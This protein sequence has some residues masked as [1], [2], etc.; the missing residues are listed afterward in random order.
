MA[1]RFG[2]DYTRG[3]VGRRCQESH[4]SGANSALPFA[5][6]G[7]CQLGNPRAKQSANRLFPVP[8]SLIG[9]RVP[10]GLKH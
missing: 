6:W 4:Q 7:F 2:T 8:Y 5:N 1:P 9:N 10:A 3:G